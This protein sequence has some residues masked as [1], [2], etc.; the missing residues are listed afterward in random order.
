MSLFRMFQRRG[1][2]SQWEEANT[3]LAAGEIGFAVDTDILKIGDGLT[4]WNE[5]LPVYRGETTFGAAFVFKGYLLLESELPEANNEISDA[6]FIQDT[7]ELHVWDGDSWIN[8]GSLVGPRGQ[9]GPQGEV[10]PQG[11][12]G[13]V[14]PQGEIGLRGDVGPEG[15]VGPQGIQG[16]VGPDGLTA[17]EVAV[18]N[19]FVGTEE[20]WLESLVGPQGIQ[21]EVGPQGEQGIQGEVGPDGL[22]AYEVAVANGFVGTEEAW[23][24][25]LVG[26]QGIQGEVGPQGEQ[27]IQGEVGPDGLTAYEVAVANGFVGTE[28]AWLESLVGPQGIQ[29]EVGPDGLTAYEVAVAN[30]FV[31]TEEAWL[32]SLVGPQGI[33]GEVGPRGEGLTIVGTVATEQDLPTTGNTENDAY[34]TL[35]DGVLWIWTDDSYWF[36]AGEVRGPVGP[37]VPSGGLAG[38]VLIKNS[39]SDYD[40]SWS[41]IID[42]GQP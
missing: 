24:E 16:E 29:G 21:G 32:E 34:L 18:A 30:G 40:T 15:P 11:I 17:Y 26:P 5:L 38:N 25:S 3:V 37:G 41:S 7:Q 8:V 6:Y 33:Q 4:P 9:T 20:A 2:A 42:G 31:S 10:G 22:T 35:D 23:L 27:G 39:G 13:E 19:G 28:E 36:N 1:L 14:G 12:Q